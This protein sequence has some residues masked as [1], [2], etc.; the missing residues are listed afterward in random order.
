MSEDAVIK[1][2]RA[3]HFDELYRLARDGDPV[4]QALFKG[5]LTPAREESDAG[6]STVGSSAA[7]KA[8]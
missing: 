8:F 5:E 4:A 1:A 6:I 3:A 7:V 2:M